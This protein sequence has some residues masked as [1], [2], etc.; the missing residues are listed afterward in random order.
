MD[1]FFIYIYIY[2]I[3][4]VIDLGTTGLNNVKFVSLFQDF[5]EP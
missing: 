3:S 1:V 4:V 2:K 5:S